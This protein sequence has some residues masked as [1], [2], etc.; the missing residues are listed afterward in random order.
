[1]L[2]SW[3]LEA[4]QATIQIPTSIWMITAHVYNN[5]KL[6]FATILVPGNWWE[7]NTKSSWE[8]QFES[9]MHTGGLGGGE[10][11]GLGG[12]GASIVVIGGFAYIPSV[13]LEFNNRILS[14]KTSWLPSTY[15]T[16][17]QCNLFA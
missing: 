10:W 11:G 5:A 14:P 1:M 8:Q 6:K 13:P 15:T 7:E 9:L 4:K 2:W 16:G 17:P 12:G 3:T